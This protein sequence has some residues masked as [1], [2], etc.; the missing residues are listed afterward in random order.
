MIDQRV[1]RASSRS[2]LV[3]GQFEG[4]ALKGRLPLPVWLYLL[5]VVIPIGFTL[6]PLYMSGLRAILIVIIIPLM[7]QLLAGRFGK[8]MVIDVLFILHIVWATIAMSV[9]NPDRVI[10]N[11]G[12]AGIEFLGGYVMGRALSVLPRRLGLCVARWG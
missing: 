8:V 11:T 6:G 1:G 3:G 12:A 2:A 5:A 10:E 9:I 7:V 4:I